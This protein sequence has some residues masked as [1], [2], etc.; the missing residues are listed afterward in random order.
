MA[1]IRR[2]SHRRLAP[3]MRQTSQSAPIAMP[4]A[5]A[6]PPPPPSGHPDRPLRAPAPRAKYMRPRRACSTRDCSVASHATNPYIVRRFHSLVLRFVP[7]ATNMGIRR[8]PSPRSIDSQNQRPDSVHIR[9][10]SHVMPVGG[11]RGP[12]IKLIKTVFAS[13]SV[14]NKIRGALIR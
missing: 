13:S 7:Q 14:P 8:K 4:R 10:S 2:H 6:P 12:P 1:E 11:S 5:S 9:N 3:S